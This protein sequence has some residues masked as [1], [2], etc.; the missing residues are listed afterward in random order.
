MWVPRSS[1]SEINTEVLLV[2]VCFVH[3]LCNKRIHRISRIGLVIDIP[4]QA[5]SLHS[6]QQLLSHYVF[7]QLF[8]CA[9]VIWKKYTHQRHQQQS[10]FL[11]WFRCVFCISRRRAEAFK[12]STIATQLEDLSF[13]FIFLCGPGLSKYTNVAKQPQ[14]HTVHI[15]DVRRV[16]GTVCLSG[17]RTHK[18]WCGHI[19]HACRLADWELRK[20]SAAIKQTRVARKRGFLGAVF[21]LSNEAATFIWINKM[22]HYSGSSCIWCEGDNRSWD[23]AKCWARHDVRMLWGRCVVF[24]Y[25]A[26]H[27]ICM[28]FK[29]KTIEV[30]FKCYR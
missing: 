29:H 11:K 15:Y 22:C 2:P 16:Q 21:R 5:T 24:H 1:I 6:F 27:S 8:R 20:A 9:S 19:H 18:G 17:Y 14:T 3:Y 12:A 7:K 4:S 13:G 26:S 30:I 28:F 10:D 25:R 23:L